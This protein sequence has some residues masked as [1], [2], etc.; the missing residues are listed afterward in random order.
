MSKGNEYTLIVRKTILQK[1][2]NEVIQALTN[3]SAVVGQLLISVD[4]M[5]NRLTV[6]LNDEQKEN[7]IGMV[8]EITN[9]AGDNFP[10]EEIRGMLK[11]GYESC[12]TKL[13]MKPNT[14]EIK[15]TEIVPD[16]KI[17][18]RANDDF[19]PEIKRVVDAGY[20]TETDVR[21][22]I[23]VMTDLR[24]PNEIIVDVLRRYR[25]YNKPVKKPSTIW[26]DPYTDR[27]EPIMMDAII[28]MLLGRAQVFEGPKSVGKNVA[29]ET[30]AWLFNMPFYLITFNRYMCGDDIFGT[31]TTVPP[32][33][34]EYT[35]E[36]L[37]QMSLCQ[38]KIQ[39]GVK[40]SD[41]EMKLAS[42][43][44]ALSA[45]ASSVCIKQEES[46]LV[47]A[48]RDGGVLCFNEMNLAEANFF[49]SFT[50]QITDNTG[51][52]F[53]SATGRIDINPDFILIGTQNAGYVG[54]GEQNEATMSRFGCIQ[55]G[56]PKEVKKQ[57]QTAVGKDKLGAPYFNQCNDLYMALLSA[58]KQG[59]ISDNCLNIRGFVAALNAVAMYPKY[60]KLAS[61]IT[62]QII[63]TCPEADR[64]A[65]SAQVLDKINL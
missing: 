46:Q 56:F 54:T 10:Q 65:L 1:K 53:T 39:T 35:A 37:E 58:C 9:A 64:A 30:L 8:E 2:G 19:E 49:S 15:F 16:V 28:N 61:Q 62:T 40:V 57:L 12:I 44:M 23:Q 60:T 22:R 3:G 48:L 41:E 11:T 7:A 25:K 52:L 14:F 47:D 21:E 29:I 4:K 36:E 24:I 32:E 17:K 63:N 45:K 31:K 6:Y 42:K 51:F 59:I 38:L 50:N 27:D 18:K 43:F 13:G 34:S 5:T 33:I 26:V 55:F 20:C